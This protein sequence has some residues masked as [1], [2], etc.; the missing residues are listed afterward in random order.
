MTF[1]VSALL[2]RETETAYFSRGSGKVSAVVETLLAGIQ[3][4]RAPVRK[5]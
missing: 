5:I 2:L 4:Q 1:L 3:V